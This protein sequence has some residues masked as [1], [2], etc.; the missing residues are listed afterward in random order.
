MKTACTCDI[1]AALSRPGS[2]RIHLS[3]LGQGL[4][5]NERSFYLSLAW[6]SHYLSLAWLSH[7]LSLMRPP[8]L[9]VQEC[10]LVLLSGDF[11]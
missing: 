10:L 4:E 5:A 2:R 1:I 3:F 7:Y 9:N 11:T 6:P 8:G